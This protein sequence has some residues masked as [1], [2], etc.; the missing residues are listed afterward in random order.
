MHGVDC[1][2]LSSELTRQAGTSCYR[3]IRSAVRRLGASAWLN[4]VTICP[5]PLEAT[6]WL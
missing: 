4:L 5:S 2:E 3:A 1:S 6:R